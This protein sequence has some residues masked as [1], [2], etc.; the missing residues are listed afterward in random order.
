[1]RSALALV[2]R[3]MLL[4]SVLV[5]SG[6]CSEALWGKRLQPV[7]VFYFAQSEENDTRLR[8][9][10]R[11][12]AVKHVMR[13]EEAERGTRSADLGYLFNATRNSWLYYQCLASADDAEFSLGYRLNNEIDLAIVGPPD[14]RVVH[15][16]VADWTAALDA[17]GIEYEKVVRQPLQPVVER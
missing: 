10:A 8:I 7:V 6:C 13:H 4:A 9:I 3:S 16:L 1:M 2:V 11:E 12:L 5:L 17:A 15:V 14:H